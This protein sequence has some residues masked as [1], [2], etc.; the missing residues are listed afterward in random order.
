VL[1]H[2]G[3]RPSRLISAA[4]RELQAYET[5]RVIDARVVGAAKEGSRFRL[6]LDGARE[7]SA[8]R[9]ILAYGVADILPPIEGLA[10]AWGRTA[11]QCPYCHGYE[12]GGR[13]LALLY[14]GPASL[15]QARILPDWSDDRTILTH[16]ARLTDAEVSELKQL[17]Y[18]IEPRRLQ[19]LVLQGSALEALE[20]AEGDRLACDAMFLITQVQPT[21]DIAQQL[22]CKMT[23]GPFGPHI[24]V[25][26]LQE[27]S[28]PGVFAAGDVA[29]P[30]HNLTWATADGVSAGIFSHQSLRT[31][32]NPYQRP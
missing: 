32:Q 8:L 14:S 19:R 6:L 9:L 2:D 21:S 24:H 29:R 10:S 27:T 11:L 25:D 18:R 30:I 5:S 4:R 16:G 28:V 17:G 7:I 13:R 31:P 22:G 12:F 26:R 3:V 1:G 20:F 15:H 23:D